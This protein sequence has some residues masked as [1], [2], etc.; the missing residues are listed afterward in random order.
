MPLY[1]PATVVCEYCHTDA[2][3]RACVSH[4]FNGGTVITPKSPEGWE[5]WQLQFW[6]PEC[7]AKGLSK[8]YKRASKPG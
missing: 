7:V 3:T 1:V 8:R 4:G 5:E 2:A 6:C